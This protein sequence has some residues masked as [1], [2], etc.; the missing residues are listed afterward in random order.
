MWGHRETHHIG[1]APGGGPGRRPGGPGRLGEA[2]EGRG[3]RR[4]GPCAALGRSLQVRALSPRDPGR[5]G[6]PRAEGRHLSG[7]S[8]EGGGPGATVPGPRAPPCR[9]LSPG[10]ASEVSGGAAPGARSGLQHLPFVSASFGGRALC[11][12]RFRAALAPAPLHRLLR[13]GRPTRA[14]FYFRESFNFFF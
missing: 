7:G 3:R 8:G 10:P 11:D 14:D 1:V 13:M 5:V 4:M 9:G 6:T 2:P 12:L